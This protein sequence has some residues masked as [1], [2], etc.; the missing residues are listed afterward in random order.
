MSKVFTKGLLFGLVL[1]LSLGLASFAPAQDEDGIV[2]LNKASVEELIAIEDLEMPEQLA[3][4]LVEYR[5]KNGPFKEAEDFLKIPG[6]TQ[7][8]MEDL[9][10]QVEDGKVFYDPDAEPA[11]APSKC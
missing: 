2:D 5:A 1:V 8:F 6:M 7:D 3:K 11:L 10:P 4:D 9:N